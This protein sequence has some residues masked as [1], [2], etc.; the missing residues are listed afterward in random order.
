MN[1]SVKSV[2]RI[3]FWSLI[4]VFLSACAS[5]KWS[6]EIEQGQR[7]YERGYYKQSFHELLAP[8]AAGRPQ[9]Q[10]AI[11]Y[12]YYYGYGVS[13]DTATGIFWIRKAADQHYKPAGKA[14]AEIER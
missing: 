5:P 13:Q 7:Y 1:K 2:V 8:A 12:M 9:A 10:Y 3:F 4:A 11:G 14:L 6:Q